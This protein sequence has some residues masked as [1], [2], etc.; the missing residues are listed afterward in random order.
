MKPLK[1]TAYGVFEKDGR[2]VGRLLYV[3]LSLEGAS[4]YRRVFGKC[5]CM[6]T[7]RKVT[8]TAR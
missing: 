2:R 4:T 6:C 7:V 8:I 5:G 3:S 1:Q